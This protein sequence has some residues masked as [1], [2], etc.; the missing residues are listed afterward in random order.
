MFEESETHAEVLL[1]QWISFFPLPFPLPPHFVH[2]QILACYITLFMLSKP[3][4]C[5]YKLGSDLVCAKSR[6]DI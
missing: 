1:S 3:V 2:E 6:A 4:A 5:V